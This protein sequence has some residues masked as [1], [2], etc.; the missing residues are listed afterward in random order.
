MDSGAIETLDKE[1]ADKKPPWGIMMIPSDRLLHFIVRH[2]LGDDVTDTPYSA[3]LPQVFCNFLTNVK[4][5]WDSSMMQ[6]VV[7][8]L[9]TLVHVATVGTYS[10]CVSSGQGLKLNSLKPTHE[11][12][13]AEIHHTRDDVKKLTSTDLLTCDPEKE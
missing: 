13:R 11:I 12:V 2:I 5:P 7:N 4:L 8:F 6:E 9:V 10:I 1:L 3:D